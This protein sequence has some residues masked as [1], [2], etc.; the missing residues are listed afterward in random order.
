[1]PILDPVASVDVMLRIWGGWRCPMDQVRF[2]VFE[3]AGE[4]GEH[5]HRGG[6]E[7]RARPQ[8]KRCQS[9]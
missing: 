5:Q 4:D 2:L 6:D 1:M 7:Q 3:H 8:A 9:S